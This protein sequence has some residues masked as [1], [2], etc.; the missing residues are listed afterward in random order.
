MNISRKTHLLIILFI[1]LG[2]RLG[3][4]FLSENSA[5]SGDAASYDEIAWNLVNGK[6]F[7]LGDHPTAYR[8][9]GYPFFLSGVYA[10]TGRSVQA[11]IL[12]QSVLGVLTVW[13]V[14]VL[15][16]FLIKQ[17]MFALAAGWMAAFYPFFLYYNARLLTET[18]LVFL[19]IA[20][21]CSLIYWNQKSESVARSC[22]WGLCSA[23]L[24]MTKSIF[25]PLGFIILFSKTL[26]AIRE[27]T[28]R[29]QL[30][31]LL[32][33]VLLF[34]LPPWLWTQ[35]NANVLGAPVLDTHG[36]MTCMECMVFYEVNK[37]GRFSDFFTTHPL[38]QATASFSEIERD[39]Y[40]YGIYRQFIQENPGTFLRQSLSNLKDFWR[41]YP[42]QSVTFSL[43][44][45]LLTGISLATEPFL[46]L[47]GIFGLWITRRRWRD[48][49]PVYLAIALLTAAHLITCAQMRYRLPLMP[50][51][52]V[53]SSCSLWYWQTRARKT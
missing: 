11:A 21:C 26:L 43:D 42:R 41:F 15:T 12:A 1:S 20:S 35:R 17:E 2:L 29:K 44:R 38:A 16:R 36:G 18:L 49:Y 39:H 22:L 40:F 28:L 9:P 25:L 3:T 14:I 46:L 45:N 34:L 32:A 31:A 48:L 5:P 19:L 7:V 47:A 23:F 6:G 8:M 30:T 27:H 52:I 51:F 33:G 53:F 4:V 37:E 10:I 24:G 50:F 13:L